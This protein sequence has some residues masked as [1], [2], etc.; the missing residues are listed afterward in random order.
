MNQFGYFES[1]HEFPEEIITAT[2]MIPKKMRGNEDYST[3]NADRHLSPFICG[4][5]RNIFDQALVEGSKY[6]GFAIVHGCDAT[7]RQFDLWERHV[8]TPFIHYIHHPLKNDPIALSFLISE[9]HAFKELIENHFNLTITDTQLRSSISLSNQIKQECQYLAHLRQKKDI[10]NL[11][12]FNLMKFCVENDRNQVLEFLKQKKT[13]W[14]K[15]EPFPS[16]KIPIYLTGSDVLHPDWYDFLEKANLR[17]IR[18][19]QSLGE[20]YFSHLIPHDNE[21]PLADLATY[22]LSGLTPATKHDM[23]QRGQFILSACQES[24]IIGVVSQNVKF[25]ETYAYDAPALIQKLKNAKIRVIHVE[26]DLNNKQNL[27]ILTQ[28]EA[29]Y[30]SLS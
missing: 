13:D 7:N 15:K 16:S 26:R 27:Q 14:G 1:N 2:G 12:Y 29:F 21:D 8:N 17:V 9:L 30:E 18:D 11:E 25:C 6:K 10:S 20:R 4:L 23:G 24:N 28:L 22:Y 5:A 3:K 19:D